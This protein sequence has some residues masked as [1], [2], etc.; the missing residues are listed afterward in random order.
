MQDTDDFIFVSKKKSTKK[1][2]LLPSSTVEDL[3]N[4]EDIDMNIRRVNSIE[5]DLKIRDG[6]KQLLSKIDIAR[7][8][9]SESSPIEISALVC[10]GLGKPSSCRI[11]RHQLGLLIILREH[12][13][14]S[15]EV[16]DPAFSTADK[17]MLDKLKFTVLDT[18][19]EA[20][21]TIREGTMFYMP[22]CGKPLYNNLLWANW[23]LESLPKCI[24][25]GNSFSSIVE[26]I[27]ARVMEKYFRYIHFI[28]EVCIE[29]P[30]E[31]LVDYN[32]IF[33]D[34]SLHWF[35]ID[36]VNDVIQNNKVEKH[37]PIY[38]NENI[39]IIRKS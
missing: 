26:V 19:E 20:K 32:D 39:E 2:K 10:Y 25:I 3:D 16:Y 30:I 37:E 27:P 8:S 1:R 5:H 15:C 17:Q 29:D 18:N 14:V 12:L 11:A 7:K 4:P 31:D 21:R 28:N 6:V 13:N 24:I 22:H 35:P 34:T 9:G 33:N 36:K 23:K 38:E